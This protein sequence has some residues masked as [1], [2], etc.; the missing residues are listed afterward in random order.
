MKGTEFHL[1]ILKF[2]LLL[3]KKFSQLVVHAFN[4]GTQEYRQAELCEFE[5][6]S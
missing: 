2:W 1:E 5:D 6:K 3:I 4:P